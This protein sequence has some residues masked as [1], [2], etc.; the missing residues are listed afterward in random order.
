MDL[1]ILF[2]PRLL[3]FELVVMLDVL[4]GAPVNW[5]IQSRKPRGV[6]TWHRLGAPVESSRSSRVH[7]LR[8]PSCISQGLDERHQDK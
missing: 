3:L 5:N 1:N 8:S 2:I 4:L 7:H 6:P